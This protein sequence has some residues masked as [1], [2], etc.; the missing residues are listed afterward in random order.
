MGGKMLS[1]KEH[2]GAKIKDGDEACVGSLE[3][4]L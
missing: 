1:S 2:R 4:P 3:L